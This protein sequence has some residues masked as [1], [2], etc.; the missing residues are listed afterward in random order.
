MSSSSSP[1]DDDISVTAPADDEPIPF[2]EHVNNQFRVSERGAALLASIN[3][4]VVVVAI[5]G[6]YRTGKSFLLNR[7]IGRQ[8]GFAV[9]PTVNPCTKGIWL[10]GAPVVENGRTYVFMDTEVRS[11]VPMRIYCVLKDETPSNF[12]LFVSLLPC[13]TLT[14]TSHTSLMRFCSTGSRLHAT[15]VDV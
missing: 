10:W 6:P 7:L 11:R 5:A 1:V 3:G 9:G 2:I 4:P 12:I 15:L 13:A 14:H 8:S